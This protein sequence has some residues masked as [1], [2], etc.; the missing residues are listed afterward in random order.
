MAY[1]THTLVSFGGTI[2]AD[3][4]I[5]SCGVR[6]QRPSP[7]FG[8]LEDPAGYM[9]EIATPL[10]TWYGSSDHHLAD[11]TTLDWLKVNNI[12]V[13]GKYSDPTHPNTYDYATPVEGGTSRA[14]SAILTLAISWRTATLR[15]PGSN[16]RI[17]LPVAGASASTNAGLILSP[18]V[19][20]NILTAGVDLITVL[21][22]STGDNPADPIVASGVNATNNS[23][24]SVRV[25]NVV[26]VQRRRKNELVE[27]Y[28]SQDV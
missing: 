12:G 15:G 24:T 16:G 5:W 13:N 18:A 23:I 4:D 28:Q 6:V 10:G 9:A 3:L 25:G 22:N 1:S 14:W 19:V 11:D 20:A 7:D 27:V 8:S 17:Y 2:G 26:D 21:R